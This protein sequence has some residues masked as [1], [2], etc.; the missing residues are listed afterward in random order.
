MP[1]NRQI[2]KAMHD[3]SCYTQTLQE[4]GQAEYRALLS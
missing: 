4:A 1:E 2:G 3:S